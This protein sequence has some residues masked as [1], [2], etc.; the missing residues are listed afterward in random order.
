MSHKYFRVDWKNRDGVTKNYAV[1]VT[2]QDALLMA[3]SILDDDAYTDGQF[4]ESVTVM[5]QASY[6]L[7][8]HVTGTGVPGDFDNEWQRHARAGRKIEAIKAYRATGG[9]Y[10]GVDLYGY[11]TELYYIGLKD[12]KDHVENWLREQGL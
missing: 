12:A 7:T 11:K 8:R 5:P 3:D 10:M 2:R 9:K 4:A 6:I 1:N